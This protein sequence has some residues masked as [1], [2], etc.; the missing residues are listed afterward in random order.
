MLATFLVLAVGA[1][2]DML[3]GNCF[4]A[5]TPVSTEHGLRPIERV[6]VGERVWS[7]NHRTGG[8]ELKPVLRLFRNDYDGE[9]FTLTVADGLSYPN[10]AEFG[11]QVRSHNAAELHRSALG[12]GEASVDYLNPLRASVA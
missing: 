9:L 5:G 2:L 8:W 12:T 10:G 4:V 1:S 3:G 11:E 7:F 6:R